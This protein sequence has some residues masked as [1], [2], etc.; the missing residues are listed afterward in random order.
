MNSIRDHAAPT[1]LPWA[2]GA[3]SIKR[4]GVTLTNCDSEPVQTPGCSQAH[5]VVLVLRVSDLTI[6]QVSENSAAH[7][8]LPPHELLG[9]SIALVVADEGVWRL[10]A[11]LEKEPIE[12]NPLYVFTLPARDGTAAL[13]LTLHTID[14]LAV[15]ECEPAA[16]HETLAP[17]YYALVKKSVARLQATDNLADF[18]RSVSDEVRTLTGLD[19]VMVYRFHPDFHG[20]V[21]GESRRDDL[22]SWF[23][24]H[25]PAE[26]IPRPAR[27]IFK[28]IWVRPL[29]DNG[30]PVMELMPLVN[31]DTGRALTM[32]HCALRGASVMYTEY[33]QNMGVAASLTLSLL[34]DG[35]LWGLV[36]CHHLTPTHF[37]YQMRAACEFVAQVASLQVR[38]VEQRES[39]AYRLQLE[40]AHNRMVA[41]AANASGLASMTVSTPGL[42]DAMNA[43]GAAIFHTERWWLVGDTPTEAQLAD[44]KVWLES[45]AEYQ[46]ATRPVF[47]T[48][49]LVR[50]YPAGAAFSAIASGVLALPLARNKGSAVLWFRPETM[51]TVH[52]GGNPNDKPLV[53]G[54]H[55]SRLTPRR[56][57]ELFTESVKDRALPW[58]RVE[59]EAVLRL[60]V[61]IMELVVSRAD[62][63]AVLNVDLTRSNEELDAFAYIAS[64]D[65]KEPLR[66]IS[67][68]AHT[69]LDSAVSADVAAHERLEGLLRLTQRMDTLLDALLHFSRVGRATLLVEPVDLNEVVEEALEMVAARRQEVPTTI[70]IPR[71]LPTV[72]CDRT[73]VR[74]VFMN[75]LANALKYTD[76]ASRDIEIG[77]RD[78]PSGVPAFYVR[79]NGIG[80]EPR[81]FDL[82]FTMFKRLHGREL[83]GGGS[84]AGLSIVKKLVEQHR[85]RVWLESNVGEGTTFSFT[86]TTP[87]SS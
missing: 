8:G 10:R 13:D 85:G 60:R 14:G 23:G 67:H 11:C 3:Y 33:L 76:R 51:Q 16:P 83:Y 18:C 1:P 69:L 7:L 81:H 42:L 35:E 57:F 37:P 29:P 25:Y 74:E 41:Q 38:A 20:E 2:D 27:E 47:A 87:A 77:W 86:L 72:L 21:V 73:R 12:R 79:D 58:L 54:P 71:T 28:K 6:L 61:L 59:V 80:I 56:S 70:R 50:E 75:L 62:Y 68:F 36:A 39:L 49:S 5:G 82:I 65:L 53:T 31:P 44:L 43:T 17:D 52:W 4:H 40:E 26:D 34:V 78:D 63:L 48:D 32:T 30:A 55:G 45:R 46:S 22:D 15:L 9:C 66:G 84:G 24:M 64:H 19:R